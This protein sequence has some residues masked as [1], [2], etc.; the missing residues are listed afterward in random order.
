ME[1]L[2]LAFT[3]P[4]QF[5]PRQP[6]PQKAGGLL[7]LIVGSVLIH[8]AV[9]ATLS[10]NSPPTSSANSRP[11]EAKLYTQ[12]KRPEMPPKPSEF[13]TSPSVPQD[14]PVN[15]LPNS[16]SEDDTEPAPRPSSDDNANRPADTQEKRPTQDILTQSEDSPAPPSKR[17]SSAISRGIAA[18]Q[19]LKQRDL[20]A[21]AARQRRQE[22]TSPDLH[23]GEYTPPEKVV[24][25]YE[26]NCEKGVNSSLAIV[27]GLFGGNVKCKRRDEFQQFVD[28]RLHKQPEQ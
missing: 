8:I 11:I 15:D 26:I 19:I 22:F 4:T 1:K 12:I 6:A 10:F 17:I 7:W 2:D 24:G 20:A 18:Q 27:A 21:E 9:L 25:E 13:I 3:G 28:K 23:V 14:A 5:R 16:K